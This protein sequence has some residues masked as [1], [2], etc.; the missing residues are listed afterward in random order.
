MRLVLLATLTAALAIGA[1]SSATS[2][3]PTLR[4]EVHLAHAAK[5]KPGV[6]L[7]TAGGPVYCMQ[8]ITLARNIGASLA[9]TD[10]GPDRYVGAGSRA[11]RRE[12]WGDPAY[13]AEVAKVPDQLRRQGVKISKLVLVGVSYSGFDNAELVATHP[14]LH[15]AALVIVDSYL[16][17][18]ARYAALPARHPTRTEIEAV[19]GGTAAAQRDAYEAR[20]PSHHLDGLARAMR[21]GMKL[22][23]VWSVGKEEQREFRGATCSRLAHAQWLS[24]LA[25][26]LRQPVY[27]Y[28]TQMRHAHALWDR[29]QGLLALARLRT[30]KRPLRARRVVFAPGAPLPAGSFCG[31]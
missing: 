12:D 31:V 19:V 7:L 11:G 6:L 8:L 22:V 16:D 2:A 20:S 5:S 14:E 27:G 10:Y 23:D 30:T 9:C 1:P 29:G 25:A 13:L 26:V 3:S 28:V 24:R 4:L 21:D 17:L 18:P 15:A